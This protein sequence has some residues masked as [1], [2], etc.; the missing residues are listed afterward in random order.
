MKSKLCLSLL[1]IALIVVAY[2]TGRFFAPVTIV[3]TPVSETSVVTVREG[4]SI[5][6]AK[7]LSECDALKA[8]NVALRKQVAEE[9]KAQAEDG[10][11]K[12][13]QPIYRSW[14]ERMEDF[15]KNNPKQYAEEMARREQFRK[16]ML[17]SQANREDFLNSIDLSLLTPE[18]QNTHKRYVL[19]LS[20]RAALQEQLNG[21]LESGERPSEELTSALRESFRTLDQTRE[22]V[23]TS[24]LGAMAISMGFS[25]EEA[26]GF[27]DLVNTVF[28]A[29]SGDPLSRQIRNAQRRN[30]Q[31]HQSNTAENEKNK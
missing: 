26:A 8:E 23:R 25:N 13:Q 3:E 28:D 1:M 20:E 15:K 14:K 18:Q 30:A 19:A 16:A 21:I 17:E 9:E 11:K 7:A 2:A 6:L 29:T 22:D 31:R 24:L 5:E 10:E 12:V 4:S 27:T